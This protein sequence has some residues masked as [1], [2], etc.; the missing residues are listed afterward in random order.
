M[1]KCSKC[2]LSKAQQLFYKNCRATDGRSTICISCQKKYRAT[3]IVRQRNLE[4]QRENDI[5]IRNTYGIGRRTIATYGLKLALAI[6]DRG[7]R[8]CEI[9]GDCYD[10][11]IHHIDNNGRHNLERGEEVNNSPDNLKVLCRRCHGRIHGKQN[12]GLKRK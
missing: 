8:Q 6:Y 9:C 3:K 1:K 4:R 12:K 5:K 7:G 10:L 11:T 2:G